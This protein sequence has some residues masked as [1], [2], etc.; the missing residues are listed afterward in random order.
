MN[1]LIVDDDATNLKL[2]RV[3]LE[4]AGH[5][6]LDATN[7]VEALQVLDKEKSVDGIV[8][9]ILM[10]DMDGFQLCLEVRKNEKTSALP[11]IFYTSTYS[12]PQD[13]QLAKTV[14]A[15]NYLSK[16]S[17]TPV[18][19]GA[20]HEAM[21][22]TRP[23][24]ARAAA[25]Q[26]ETYVLKQ[27]NA[28]LVRKVE[29]RNIELEAALKEQQIAHQKLQVSE[30]RVRRLNRVYAVLSG[31][32][33]LIVRSRDR[34]ELLDEACRI[35]V[36]HGGFGMVWIG[37]ANREEQ[38]VQAVAQ[39]GFPDDFG[40]IRVSLKTDNTGQWNPAVRVIAGNEPYFDNNIVSQA[41]LNP[42][43]QAAVAL[44]YRSLA[45]LP[46]TIEKVS[47]GAL[48]SYAKEPGFFSDDEMKLLTELAGDI[49]FA[50]ENIN[51][52][53]KIT[54]LSRIQAVM[55]STN[56]LSVRVRDREELFK[57]ACRIAVE[58]GRFPFAWIG[59]LD[60]ESQDVSPFAWSGEAAEGLT[61]G[62][63]SARTDSPLGKGAVGRA[64]R[65]RRPVFNNDIASHGFGG[66]R[67]GEILKLGFRSQITLPLYENQ[68]VVGTL[69][70]YARETNFF[71]AE[72]VGL[73][74]EL[75]G[76]ISFTLE[77]IARQD[78]LEKLS[79][80]RAVSGEINA[81][82]VR[83]HERT[84]LLREV[85]RIAVE[86]GKF[87]LVWIA[88]LDHAKQRVHP[89]AWA[90]FAPETANA[91]DWASMAN[92][93]VTLG[94]AMLTR[95]P[96]VRNDIGSGPP[97]GILRRE[98]ASKGCHS[99]V[100]LP[101]VVDGRVAAAVN[102]FATGRNFFVTDE[103]ALLEEMASNISFALEH[104]AR[105]QKI[106]KLS[107]IRA[108]SSE[109]NATIVRIRNR[110]TLL[111][112]TCRIAT[113]HGKFEMVWIA[114]LDFDRQKIR[115]VASAGFSQEAVNAVTWASIGNT[116]GTLGQAIQSRKTTVRNDIDPDMPAGNLRREAVKAGCLST[117]CLPLVVD[118][119][120]AA[121]IS[122]FAAGRDFFDKD[123]LALL[124]ELA[125]DVSL[126]LQSIA[127]QEKVDY[128]SYYDPLTALPNRSLFVDRLTQQLHG[129]GGEQLMVA[130]ILLNLE[131]FR[132]I[133]ETLGRHGGDELLKIVAQRLESAFHGKDYLARVGADG[134][135]AVIR[136]VRD[137]AAVAHALQDQILGCFNKP[138]RL[139]DNELRVAAKA[140]VAVFPADGD[141]ADT[142]FKNAEAA[143]KKA[144]DSGERY[145]FY[146]ADM[147][148][149]AAQVLSLETRL[150][151]AVEKQEFVLHY[152]P[153]YTL[154]DG[155]ICGMEA[156][157]R[158]QDPAS[159]LVPPGTFIPLLEETGLILEV[160]KWALGR[161]LAQHREWT[162]AGLAAPRIAVNVSPIQLQQKDFSDI[163]INVV[164]EQG[165][166]PDAL[167][168]EVTE[169][170]LMK[171]VQSSIRKLSI[172]RGMGI[173]IAM[174]DFG[175]GY[176][177]LA[178]IARLPINSIK[179][180]RSF[181]TGM[182][183]SPQDMGIVTTIIALAHSMNL[184]VVAEG[185]ETAEQSQ[186]L[187]LLK[188]DEAQGYLFS[189]P[190]PAAEIETLLRGRAS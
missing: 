93:G 15:D 16:P 138:F 19:L 94:E 47:V 190:L 144:R 137:T 176:S 45:I 112:E 53:R 5:S 31:I 22:R 127:Q 50:L 35:A 65:E 95:R 25:Q 184:K 158:W 167:E 48:F 188:C 57:G 75:A 154:A 115:P 120:V 32:N 59:V 99:T 111:Q 174:D 86:H 37:L 36:E 168:L 172:L 80:I 60:A 49:S 171:D 117:V 133:N 139:N 96:A 21:Q 113:E 124:N 149:R 91:V 118:N 77:H 24:I 130:V 83:I 147:N 92:P 30:E 125:A 11:F 81:A 4:A 152:Q 146:A 67:L 182:T 54:H 78:K 140:G 13:Q 121:L 135:G 90:G 141:D 39:R 76:D 110:E 150:R 166:N 136:G 173:T 17:P 153:K 116:Q 101:F 104:I 38:E 181:I 142:L 165:D 44:G 143:L 186:L 161:A 87:E 26:D 79:R 3:Q 62:K 70:M 179:I 34:Q 52:N 61:K 63:S 56:A 71:D 170:L 148:A 102:L 66:P 41:E 132:N 126:A 151:R 23:R 108:V 84:A 9:D 2:L 114:A 164:Q 12:S 8:S 178:Y 129:R 20:L 74:T 29:Q 119:N 162:A 122:L 156:L 55:S 175:T 88:T 33:T 160:G 189:K 51:K 14:G 18:I 64:I 128:L 82:I 159:G 109:I 68:G 157:I 10:P 46:L 106:T 105:Q 107:R 169:S 98:A 58:E 187:K 145:L 123:E 89:V 42:M 155:K 7:G 72:E 134:F 185:V 40:A 177:S 85:C 131:R 73:L 27:Y 97:A 69:T 183:G 103:L 6:V 43:R 1:L 28:S 163:V 180:D 100:C